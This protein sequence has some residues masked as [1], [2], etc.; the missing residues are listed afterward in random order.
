MKRIKQLLIFVVAFFF[1]MSYA[2]AETVKYAH[3]DYNNMN[4]RTGPGTNHS[5]IKTL[6][7]NSSYRLALDNVVPS[8]S[9]CPDGW[10]KIYY[11]G[12]KT[13]YICGGYV[14]IVDVEI[15][16]YDTNND[17]EADLKQK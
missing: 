3:I 4:I 5:V 17:C 15:V 9:T 16:D 1:L 11:S 2:S 7:I 12:D 14:T 13:G 6:A 10:Y 8:E